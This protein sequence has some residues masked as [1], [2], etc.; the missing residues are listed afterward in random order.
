[1]YSFGRISTAKAL[2]A[3]LHG[4]SVGPAAAAD[5]ARGTVARG[6]FGYLDIRRAP[7]S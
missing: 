4:L 1:L 5:L 2:D 7:V 3:G 6:A